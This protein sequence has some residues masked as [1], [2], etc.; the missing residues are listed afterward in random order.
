MDG[1]FR[2]V[3]WYRIHTYTDNTRIWYEVHTSLVCNFSI[4]VYLYTNEYT[5]RRSARTH[6]PSRLSSAWSGMELEEL[7]E[8]E[9]TGMLCSRDD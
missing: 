4:D 8:S 9:P 6:R 2:T 1:T 3:R 7:E 5:D